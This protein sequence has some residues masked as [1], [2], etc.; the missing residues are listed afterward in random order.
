MSSSLAKLEYSFKV[1]KEQISDHQPTLT[2]IKGLC[3]RRKTIT[4]TKTDWSDFTQK[5]SALPAHIPEID[6]T[7]KLDQFSGVLQSNISSVLEHTTRTVTISNRPKTLLNIPSELLKL[8]RLKRKTSRKLAKQNSTSLRKI[9]NMLNHR[10]KHEINLLK[11]VNLHSNFKSLETSKAQW[12]N[13]G[14]SLRA[15][16]TRRNKDAVNPTSDTKTYTSTKT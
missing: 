9:Y 3:P 8:I 14:K 15:S 4:F 1:L 12:Q 13:T 5:L 16:T 10:I 7:A 11:S 6:T 2:T